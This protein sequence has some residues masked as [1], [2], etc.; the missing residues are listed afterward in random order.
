MVIVGEGA[1]TRPD[2]AAVLAAAAKVAQELGALADKWVGFGVLHTAASR[3]G[4]LDLG[5]VP[6]E[7]GRDAA[8]ML[9]EP[10]V[11]LLMGADEIE[12]PAGVEGRT[13]VYMGHH[14][15]R[16]AHAA[17]VILPAACYT[18]KSGTFVNLEGRVQ[19]TNRAIFVPGEAKDDWAI[20]RALSDILGHRLPFDSMAQLRSRLYADHPHFAAIDEVAELDDAA[21]HIRALAERGGDMVDEPFHPA[22]E[23]FYLTNAILRSSKIMADCSALALAER[24][25]AV[26]EAAE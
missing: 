14:G 24:G 2:G 26:A 6:G 13:V 25:D 3:V 12:V 23:D 9:R 18:E 19:M 20:V 22:V 10:G 5:F 11:V 21:G 17:D 16:G 4:G 1:V 15:D 7:G 8:T